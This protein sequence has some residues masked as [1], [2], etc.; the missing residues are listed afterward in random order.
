MSKRLLHLTIAVND[1]RRRA[2][3]DESLAV[4]LPNVLRIV[5]EWFVLRDFLHLVEK[6]WRETALAARRHEVFAHEHAPDGPPGPQLDLSVADLD[7]TI[8]SVE[9][10]AGK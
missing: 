6:R 3:H 7:E 2:D 4:E 5:D 10:D 8:G 9:L 1:D